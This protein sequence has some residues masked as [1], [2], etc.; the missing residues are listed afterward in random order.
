VDS[1]IYLYPDKNSILLCINNWYSKIYNDWWSVQFSTYIDPDKIY[2][3]WPVTRDI[4]IK[5]IPRWIQREF[6]SFYLMPG[7]FD[8]VEWYHPDTWHNDRCY[9]VTIGDLLYKFEETL[10]QI[11][12]FCNL[13]YTLPIVE[14]LP[15]H[16]QN[17]QNQ[18][19][20]N[21]DLLCNRIV[22]AVVSGEEFSWDQRSLV[23]ESWIQWQ[24]RN[25]GYEIQCY[26][27]DKFPTNSVH[28]KELLYT[29]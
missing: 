25:L 6:L 2:N 1:I 10:K 9:I 3:N 28:L 11:E 14:L 12:L 18:K 27:L 29:I 19:Y 13:K 20:L 7:W 17:L 24:L 26:E 8:Q 21:E 23:S 5:N 4:E 15:Y 16:H 22:D